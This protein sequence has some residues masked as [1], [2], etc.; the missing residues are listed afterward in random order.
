MGDEERG[1]KVI[2]K[3][4]CVILRRVNGCVQQHSIIFP[5]IFCFYLKQQLPK[6]ITQLSYLPCKTMCVCARVCVVFIFV[7]SAWKTKK[8]VTWREIIPSRRYLSR[9]WCTCVRILLKFSNF[10]Y[11]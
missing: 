8:S 4:M 2:Y 10:C 11:L 6:I 1:G 7:C 9:F 3:G 5:P